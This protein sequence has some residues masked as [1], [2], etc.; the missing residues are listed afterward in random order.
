[1]ARVGF[2]RTAIAH[3]RLTLA[4]GVLVQ[5]PEVVMGQGELGVDVDGP[6]EPFDRALVALG[7]PAHVLVDVE[8]GPSH[9]APGV[10]EA[11]LEG[12]VEL[13]PGV[14]D[15]RATPMDVDA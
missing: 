10:V 11:Q 12:P 7:V 6:Q 3:E 1:M 4:A 13:A 5:H 14:G 8:R 15:R 2:H 9:Q